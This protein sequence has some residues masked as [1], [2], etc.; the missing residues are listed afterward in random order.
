MNARIEEKMKQASLTLLAV[1]A[2]LVGGCAS[3]S[4]T[5]MGTEPEGVYDASTA[6]AAA[7]GVD[8]FNYNKRQKVRPPNDFQFYFKNCV[9][10]EQ[11][12]YYS[13]TSYWCQDN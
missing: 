12:S 7:F 8:H 5:R 13:R 10:N 6:D 4:D 3:T 9:Q 1:A 11:R 2:T